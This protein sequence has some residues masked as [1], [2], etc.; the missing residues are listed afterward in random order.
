MALSKKVSEDLE[1]QIET[2]INIIARDVAEEMHIP[3]DPL[4][5]IDV[6]TKKLEHELS[7]CMLLAKTRIR[8]G[9]IYC[10]NAV[11]EMAHTDSSIDLK[12]LEE[13]VETALG[14]F[15]TVAIVKDMCSKVIDGTSWKSLLGLHD[16]SVDL[17]Y[18]GAK[19][20]FDSGRYPE[21]EAAFF[22]LTTIDFAEYVFW[23]GLGHAAFHLGNINQALNAYDMASSCSP[24]A[25][26]PRIYMANCFEALH[27]FEES[28]LALRSA[29]QELKNSPDK[30]HA[31]EMDLQE[32]IRNAKSRA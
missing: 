11:K 27:D 6:Q 3:D 31:L 12:A 30:D 25:I 23:L 13:N 32:R 21:S 14:R 28:L 18:R 1:Q 26:W 17:F 2:N 8:D 7:Q 15:E 22:F 4:Q 10:V 16:T 5:S 20:L 29:E 24:N 9:F 19:K